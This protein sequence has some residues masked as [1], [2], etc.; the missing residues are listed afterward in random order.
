MLVKGLEVTCVN[1]LGNDGALCRYPKEIDDKFGHE[2]AYQIY[3]QEIRFIPESE[4]EISLSCLTPFG[5]NKAEICYGDLMMPHEVSFS[6]KT[7]LKIRPLRETVDEKLFC[8]YKK[9]SL[10]NPEMV[11][12]LLFSK[13]IRIDEVK[14]SFRLPCETDIPAK[15]ML[16][17]GTS[18]SQGTAG[19]IASG[20]YPF[21]LARKLGMNIDNYSL[22]GQC[23]LD[24]VINWLSSFDKRYDLIL[25]EPSTNL[26]AQGYTSEG[27]VKKAKYALSCFL[28]SY[29]DA[30]IVC[31]DLF[32]SLFDY[33]VNVPFNLQSDP[34][35]YRVAFGE[36]IDSFNEK[37]LILV[38][39]KDLIN[40]RNFSLD[41]MHPSTYGYF[42]IA[43][44]LYKILKERGI[45]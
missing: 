16:V 5:E 29:P 20:S 27:F 19:H 14:G 6:D 43:E 18:L 17:Y 7:K 34:D 1:S 30:D 4:V 21:I 15:N 42:E 33:G 45:K 8:L 40:T 22:A 37:R 32:E 28:S 31:I 13:R 9:I 24:D 26:L 10:Y 38:H 12:I 23:L 25:F 36:V 44:N 3:C 35:Q 2:I 39:A 11:R 41:L